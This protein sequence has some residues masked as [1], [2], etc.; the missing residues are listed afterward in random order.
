[1][2]QIQCNNRGRLSRTQEE[3]FVETKPKYR[4]SQR[5]QSANVM[6]II[7]CRPAVTHSYWGQTSVRGNTRHALLSLP[8]SVIEL[9]WCCVT[10]VLFCVPGKRP[11]NW[12]S[13]IRWCRKQT[14]PEEICRKGPTEQD[15]RERSEARGT[16]C[17]TKGGVTP[18]VVQ[19]PTQVMYR[20][21][22]NSTDERGSPMIPTPFQESFGSTDSRCGILFQW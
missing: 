17:A 2:P 4:N 22:P 21:P 12:P 11:E 16:Q 10:G 18:G 9:L 20:L 14:R 8:H 13:G 6:N 7:V 15:H 3:Y 1:M 19:M 5:T